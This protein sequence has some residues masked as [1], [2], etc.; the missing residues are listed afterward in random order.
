[1]VKRDNPSAFVTAFSLFMS[2][3]PSPIFIRSLST[4]SSAHRLPFV[5]HP[6]P[7]SPVVYALIFCYFFGIAISFIFSLITLFL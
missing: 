1:M 4:V 5:L 3:H 6:P 2:S 7:S